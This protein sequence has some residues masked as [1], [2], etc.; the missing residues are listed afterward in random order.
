MPKQVVGFVL[1]G[2]WLSV[3]RSQSTKMVQL[4]D[5]TGFLERSM[6]HIFSCL[7]TKEAF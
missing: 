2:K 6:T 3:S 4:L 5:M 1:L 7:S